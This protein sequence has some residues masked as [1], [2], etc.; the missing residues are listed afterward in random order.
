MLIA[1]RPEEPDRAG[2]LR[3]VALGIGAEVAREKRNS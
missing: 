1:A 3:E 2:S